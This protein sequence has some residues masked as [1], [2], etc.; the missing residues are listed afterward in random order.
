MGS[1]IMILFFFGLSEVASRTKK[2]RFLIVH[3]GSFRNYQN[4]SLANTKITTTT[5]T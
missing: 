5:T 4:I 3:C 1:E 2:Q